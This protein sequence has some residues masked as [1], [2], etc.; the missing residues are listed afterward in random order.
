MHILYIRVYIYHFLS[1]SCSPSLCQIL[2]AVNA[3][4]IIIIIM[5]D[6]VIYVDDF[7]P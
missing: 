5:T 3:N 4:F 6:H 1:L 7:M 2:Y